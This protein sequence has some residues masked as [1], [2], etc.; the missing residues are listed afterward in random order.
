M[1]INLWEIIFML[2]IENL[3]REM[4]FHIFRY[5]NDKDLCNIRCL[6]Q[7]YKYIVDTPILYQGNSFI[8]KLLYQIYT[9]S[10]I[11]YEKLKNKMNKINQILNE[12]NK[13]LGELSITD[14][15][16]HFQVEFIFQ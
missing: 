2:S 16:V 3:P 8:K 12:L 11:K 10:K 9:E 14:S 6:N 5:L 4:A 13:K 1:K 7:E 15:I